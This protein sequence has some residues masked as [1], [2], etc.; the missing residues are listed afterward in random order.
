MIVLYTTKCSN[1]YS[2]FGDQSE[3]PFKKCSRVL[4]MIHMICRSVGGKMFARGLERA[5][6]GVDDLD[7]VEHFDANAGVR[8]VVPSL[9]VQKSLCRLG[10]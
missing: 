10:K 4:K 9:P 2:R 3:S 6:L 7:A 8:V 5:L 1:L